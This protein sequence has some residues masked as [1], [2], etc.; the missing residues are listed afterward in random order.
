MPTD[1]VGWVVAFLVLSIGVARLGRLITYDDYPPAEWLRL[2]WL[3]LVGDKWGKLMTCPW[4]MNP[5]LVAVGMAW[6]YASDLHWT[7]WAF[8]GW[9]AISQISSTI[10]AYDEPE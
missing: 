5:Y 1:V 10:S 8:W 4:C 3:T 6:G 2:K 7:W 9:L